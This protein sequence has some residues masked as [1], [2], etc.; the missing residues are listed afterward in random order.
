MSLTLSI[1]FVLNTTPPTQ[2]TLVHDGRPLADAATLAEAGVAAGAALTA[3]LRLRGGGGD[4]GSTGAE[5]RSCY[6]E[7]YAGKKPDKADAA[8]VL[9]A[10]WTRCHLSGEP[11]AEPVA[12]DE[13]GS[14]FNKE[15]VVTA[16]LAKTL[17]AALAHIGSLKQL[18]TLKLDR[19][20]RKAGGGGGGGA[21]TSGAASLA[22]GGAAADFQC[23]LT[24]LEMNGRARFVVHRPTGR[25]VAERALKDAPAAV[26]EL[27]GGPWTAADLIPL[28]PTGDELFELREALAARMAAERQKKLAKKLA[29]RAAAAGDGNGTAA[30]AA[31]AAGS[32]G[33]GSS[34][35]DGARG[36]SPG[37]APAAAA[38]AVAGGKRPA[39]AA[40][41]PAAAA[42][43]ASGKPPAAKKPKLPEGMRPELYNSLFHSAEQAAAVKETF[44][45]RAC[46]GR[47]RC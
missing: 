32:G 44:T 29:K 23:P 16:L 26:E 4:G 42:A 45:A 18:V 17:P 24:G 15:A 30:A 40:A 34:G 12:C 8:E 38:A 22:S 25:A 46:S 13:L 39:P 5:S 41:A 6:L 19:V 20:P 2:Q 33:G 35:S 27:F 7:M 10:R 14:L 28:N 36:G 3:Q 1:L 47:W 11:L 37:N 9:R 43:A 31:A 21:V